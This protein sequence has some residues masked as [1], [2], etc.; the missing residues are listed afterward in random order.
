[1][2]LDKKLFLHYTELN[3]QSLNEGNKEEKGRKEMVAAQVCVI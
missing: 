2:R 3:G 1:M